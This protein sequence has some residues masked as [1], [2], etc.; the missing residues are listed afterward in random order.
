MANIE[1]S[2]DVNSLLISNGNLTNSTAALGA[3]GAPVT[4]TSITAKLGGTVPVANKIGNEFLK[5]TLEVD[6][7]SLTDHTGL[8][9]PA[10]T[11]GQKGNIAYFGN[12]PITEFRTLRFISNI[13]ATGVAETRTLLGSIA[14][15]AAFNV[16]DARTAFKIKFDITGSNLGANW[17]FQIVQTGSDTIYY[18]MFLQAGAASA[19]VALLE[20][21]G[22][23]ECQSGSTF[24]LR[25]SVK[26]IIS[27][28][29]DPDPT[30]GNK[31]TLL[32]PTYVTPQAEFSSFAYSTAS[33][34]QIYAFEL[35]AT[36]SNTVQ[37]N[38]EISIGQ[39]L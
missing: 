25:G 24:A 13:T 29:I 19:K 38:G 23:I 26:E 12:S 21:D 37:I 1:V 3:L 7:I 35:S 20:F 15:P 8:T 10:A 28:A 2:A 39:Q 36:V 11:L 32:G 33:T 16:L 27:N 5:D 22:Y 18:G 34:L 6:Y 31:V 9:I 4:A 17:G 30:V 14:V